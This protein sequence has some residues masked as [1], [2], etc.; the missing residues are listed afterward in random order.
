MSASIHEIRKGLNVP[1]AGVPDQMISEGPTVS[2][3]ALIGD[4]YV[5]MKPTMLVQEGDSVRSGQPVFEDKK[6][7]GL[8]YTSPGAGVVR[9]VNRGAKRKF[10]SLVIELDGDGEEEFK[11]F[12]DHNLENLARE[13]VVA[14]LVAAGLWTAIRTRPYSKVPDPAGRPHSIFVTVI[15]TNPLSVDP[16]MVLKLPDYDRYFIHG[17]QAISV[18]TDGKVFV[19]KAKGA[20]VPDSEVPKV[21]I[22]EFDGP[23]PSGLV[24]THVHLLDPVSEQKTVW[25]IGYQDVIAIGHL[26]LEGKL[27]LDRVVSIAGPGVKNPAIVRTRMG[28]S[29]DELVHGNVADGPMRVISGSA[30]SGRTSV[31]PVDYLGRFHTQVTVLHDEAKRELL[32]WALPGF[33]KYSVT[34][35]FASNFATADRRTSVQFTTAAEGSHRAIV[36]IGT[37]ERVMPLD[38]IPTA[39]LKSLIVQDTETAQMLGCLELDEEDLALCTFVCPGKNEYGPLLRQCLTHIEREG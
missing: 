21:A 4:D 34:R 15:D 31:S 28:A 37:Y 8:L 2:R 9:Q 23:H 25:H 29:L 13:Q 36:P 5:G 19:C 35:A 39:L 14:N 7:P 6:T 22:N 24:G 16:A 10:E 32:G 17:L 33:S 1:L 3:V 30:L 38:I 11:T 27:L 18:L 12:A 20:D 26:F